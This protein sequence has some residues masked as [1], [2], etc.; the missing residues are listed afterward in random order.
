ML[1]LLLC[2]GDQSRQNRD[3]ARAKTIAADFEDDA[4]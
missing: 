3:I 4:R 2:G 1:F